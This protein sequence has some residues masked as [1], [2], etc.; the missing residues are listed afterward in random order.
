MIEPEI[1]TKCIDTLIENC[2]TVVVGYQIDSKDPAIL[3]FKGNTLAQENIICSMEFAL[4]E[5]N[6]PENDE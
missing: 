1:I 5:L 4:E 3:A 6:N 2:E